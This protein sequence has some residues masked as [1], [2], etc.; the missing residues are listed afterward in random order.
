MDEAISC[1]DLF[2]PN[3][4]LLAVWS[5]VHSLSICLATKHWNT[6]FLIY[7]IYISDWSMT[8][9]FGKLITLNESWKVEKK[10]CNCTKEQWK[11]KNNRWWC[12]MS[13]VV[14]L[15]LKLAHC[16]KWQKK[17][18]PKKVGDKLHPSWFNNIQQTSGEWG[19]RSGQ[20]FST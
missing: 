12:Y 9:F 19:L 4:P 17:C 1:A 11:E 18:V 2:S 3:Y 8:H 16:V 15:N 6:G 7:I 5:T 14:Y 13:C 10:I 20:Q